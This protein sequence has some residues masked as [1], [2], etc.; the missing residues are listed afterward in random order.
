VKIRA[1][2]LK[3]ERAKFVLLS[4]W[5]HNVRVRAGSTD[6]RCMRLSSIESACD[7]IP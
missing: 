7:Q 5:V 4:G 3:L 1:F 6:T 2:N